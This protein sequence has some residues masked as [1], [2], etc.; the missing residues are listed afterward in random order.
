MHSRIPEL[1]T[2]LL[3]SYMSLMNTELPGLMCGFYIQGSIALD[4]F[5]EHF[6]DVDFITIV[7]RAPSES[8]VERLKAIHQTLEGKYPRWSLE[9]SYVHL[10]GT[11]ITPYLNYHDKVLRPDTYVDVNDVTWWVLKN[12][13]IALFGPE[14]NQLDLGVN[15][16]VL[17]ANMRHNLN[18]YWVQYTRKPSRIAWLLTD[19]GIQWA[20]LGVLRQFYSFNEHSI[21]SKTGA[22]EYGLAHLSNKWH[23]LIQEALNIRNKTGRSLYNLRVLR[24]VEA[25]RFLTFLIHLCN[26]SLM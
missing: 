20:V 22:G 18:T 25:L 13:G 12:R 5:N 8:D 4:A 11:V 14:P 19:Y 2:P 16:N 3:D 7:R 21:T 1:V 24:A 6:S 10:N 26:H 23:R 9:G 15:W 17:I